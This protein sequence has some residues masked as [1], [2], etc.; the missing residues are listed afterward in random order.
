MCP[1]ELLRCPL[2]RLQTRVEKSRVHAP[3]SLLGLRGRGRR[4]LGATVFPSPGGESP[5]WESLVTCLVQLQASRGAYSCAG[6]WRSP[7]TPALGCS[8]NPPAEGWEHSHRGHGICQSASQGGPAGL[9]GEPGPRGLGRGI[10]DR[11]GLR[12]AKRH[13]K[14]ACVVFH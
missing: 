6:G 9:V 4:C 3:T 5:L 11:G 13:R 10:A 7:R 2:V 14:R 1:L 12:L 8:H